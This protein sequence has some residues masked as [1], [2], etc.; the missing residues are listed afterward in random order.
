MGVLLPGL[1]ARRVGRKRQPVR[2]AGQRRARAPVQLRGGQR[3]VVVRAIQD[4][5]A[6][7]RLRHT[8]RADRR[9]GRARAGRGGGFVVGAGRR[10]GAGR[11]AM[12]AGGGDGGGP[13]VGE[14]RRDR[15]EE[16]RRGDRPAERVAAPDGAEGDPGRADPATVVCA[17]PGHV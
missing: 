16:V 2:L 4:V 9:G 17:A 13:V 8:A 14:P 11:P 1:R 5:A 12:A 7:L 15:E 3:R 6:D 10:D